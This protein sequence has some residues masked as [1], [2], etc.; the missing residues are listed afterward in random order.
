MQKVVR[1]GSGSGMLFDSTLGLHQML[2]SDTPPDYVIF[3][4]LA[5]ATMSP[6]LQVMEQSPELGYSTNIIDLHVGPYLAE[7]KAAGVKVVTNAGGLNPHAA[8]RA[9]K[10]RANEIGVTLTVG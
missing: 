7:L 3:D 9:L 4:H 10:K 2:R 6:F 1:I 5:E 8:A